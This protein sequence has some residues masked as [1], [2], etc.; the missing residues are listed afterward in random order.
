MGLLLSPNGQATLEF[1][2]FF[3]Y[4][5]FWLSQICMWWWQSFSSSWCVWRF[6]CI[7]CF[8]VSS[9]LLQ[10]VVSGCWF[11]LLWSTY[12]LLGD[13][14]RD[15]LIFLFGLFSVLKQLML[16]HSNVFGIFVCFSVSGMELETFTVSV[17]FFY[18]YF[19]SANVF[20]I[21]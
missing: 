1:G 5:I 9:F 21:I 20:V 11:C 10:M 8:W 2:G 14:I 13:V 19:S 4:Y 3:F 7:F 18:F 16:L 17:Y 12:L 15:Y 6:A